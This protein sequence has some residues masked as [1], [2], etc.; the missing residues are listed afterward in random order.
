MTILGVDWGEKHTGLALGW[1]DDIGLSQ[2]LTTVATDKAIAKILFVCQAE[3][4]QKIIIG[5]SERESGRKAQIFA[6]KLKTETKI[7]I[8]LADETL[9]TAQ[10]RSIHKSHAAAAAFILELWLDEHPPNNV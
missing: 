8:E 10:A 6:A 7:P 1:A 2:P 3:S 9:S 4:V 5:V